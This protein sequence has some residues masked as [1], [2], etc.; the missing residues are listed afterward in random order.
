M[1]WAMS[2]HALPTPIRKHRETRQSLHS[3]RCPSFLETCTESPAVHVGA[4]RGC[5]KWREDYLVF[6]LF[7]YW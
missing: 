3:T 5:L 6:P 2:K 4:A 1:D 7:S